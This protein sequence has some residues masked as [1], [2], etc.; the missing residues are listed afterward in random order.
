MDDELEGMGGI[1]TKCG[2]DFD[3]LLEMKMYSPK[4]AWLFASA[5][6]AFCLLVSW[7]SGVMQSLLD[8]EIAT[9]PQMR[10][11]LWWSATGFITAYAVFAYCYIWPKGT[12]SHGR[13]LHLSYVILFG[14]L[15]GGCQG[16]LVVAIY[17]LIDSFGL[18]LFSDV[19]IM[20]LAYSTLTAAWHSRFWDIYVSPDHNIYEWNTRKVLIAHIPFLVLSVF[21]LAV[22]DNAAIFVMWQIIALLASSFVMRFPAPGDPEMPAHDGQGVRQAAT[23]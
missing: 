18:N 2:A 14:V 9:T 7:Q 15:W 21:H 5:Y 1:L 4:R 13:P 22:F 20:L 19:L 8:A 17:R 11:T 12:L 10:D 3:I 6:F 16:Q 23:S